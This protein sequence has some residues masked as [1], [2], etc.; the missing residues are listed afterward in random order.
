[1]TASV[2]QGRSM[3]RVEFRRGQ[4]LA[5]AG[6]LL[7]AI[8]ASSCCM[9]PLILFT[10]GVSGSWIGNL[11]QLAPYQP[12]FVAMAIACLS[13]GYR[14]VYRSAQ[15]SCPVGG[16]A[17]KRLVKRALFLATVLVIAAMGFKLL[18]PLLNS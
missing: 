6:G 16:Y 4:Y 1:M 17:S 8:A 13:Y 2:D 11:V 12:Y 7:G 9:L 10:L 5:A 18:V 14:L 3:P 15:S